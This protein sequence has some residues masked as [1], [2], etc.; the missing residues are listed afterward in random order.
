MRSLLKLALIVGLGL[1]MALASAH[2]GAPGARAAFTDTDGDGAIDLAEEV[3]GSNPNGASST[4]ET[5]D[6]VLLSLTDTGCT[7]GL[8][9]DGDGAIDA[10]DG[11]CMDSD[12]AFP[13]DETELV[14]G[15]DPQNDESYPEDS[16][17]DTLFFSIGY[18][19]SGCAD[20]EDDDG[21]GL[22]DAADPGCGAVD[23]DSDGFEDYVEKSLGSDWEDANSQP[24]HMSVN[25]GSCTDATD[26]DGDA[27]TDAAD[28]GCVVAPNDDVADAIVVD[29]LPFS[30]SAKAVGTTAEFGERVSSCSG[31][32]GEEELRGTLWYKFTADAN[33]HVLIDA[34]GSDLLTS[35]S[36]W[37]DGPFGLQEVDCLTSLFIFGIPARFAFEATAG[38]T[39]FVQV[40]RLVSIPDLPDFVFPDLA[41][42]S[43]HMDATE[44]PANDDFAD[45]QPITGLPFSTSADTVAAS[46]EA[47]EPRASC[48][49]QGYPANSVWYRYTPAA[50][51][52]MQAGATIGT[53]FGVTVGAF[54]GTSLA[55]LT[56]VACGQGVL[57]FRAEAGHTYYLQ[58][59]GY[60]CR[61]PGEDGGGIAS[62]CFDSRAG[63]VALHVESIAVPECPAPQ[64][65]VPDRI[66]DQIVDAAQPDILSISGAAFSDHLCLTVHL[67]REIPRYET[68][69]VG[70]DLDQDRLTGGAGYAAG[71]VCRRPAG[72]GIDTE[73][74]I[75]PAEGL[76]VSPHPSPVSGDAYAFLIVDRSSLNL[77]FPLA[78]LGDDTNVGF[79]AAVLGHG[80]S[81]DCAP[82]GGNITCQKAV[83][84]FVAFRNGDAN[85]AG[86]ANAIDAALVLQYS[87]GLL[88]SLA[89]PE[90]ADV[91]GDERIDSRDAALILQYAAGLVDE[92]PPAFGRFTVEGGPPE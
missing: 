68:S 34:S 63:H 67:D 55:S 65:T 80:Q 46:I 56:Q 88:S 17:F 11:G 5:T 53:D 15:S 20:G 54:E 91:T 71:T 92:L 83:C 87:A 60:T 25:P 23:A 30:Y 70:L 33:T 27:L 24:E 45:A 41:R 9:N 21:D 37:R 86:G 32:I 75:R 51:T 49:F 3:F 1:V 66:G 82:D 39:Y 50:D 43:F 31:F 28:E 42:L 12:G 7:D 22:I 72:L 76:L 52:Y 2:A 69:N 64:F 81:S 61:S 14:L 29:S 84:A 4:P 77:I 59:A 6:A 74:Y 36:V 8:D 35:V 38:E 79:V 18:F 78:V 48:R 57:G 47:S 40:E 13:S 19:F 16:R 90:A 58:A 73:F 89:C 62:I 26:N 85:C 10:K 44:P